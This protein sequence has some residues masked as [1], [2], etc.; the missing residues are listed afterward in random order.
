[1]TFVVIGSLRVNILRPPAKSIIFIL[2]R[3]ELFL[4]SYLVTGK[5][6]H[7]H[8]VKCMVFCSPQFFRYIFQI[9][10]V[11]RDVALIYRN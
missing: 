9:K 2:Y 8:V 1:M 10:F 7:Y 5:Y 6:V 4:T 11:S 3:P